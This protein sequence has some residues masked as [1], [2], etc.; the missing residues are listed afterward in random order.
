MVL[1]IYAPFPVVVVVQAAFDAHF[2]R[3]FTTQ[4]TYAF[5]VFGG[6]LLLQILVL[7]WMFAPATEGMVICIGFALGASCCVVQASGHQMISAIDPTKIV[8]CE[9]G[10]QIGS[11][12][13][14]VMISVLDFKPKATPREF[15]EFIAIPVIVSFSAMAVLMV[16]HLSGFFYK[17]YLRLAYDLE[18]DDLQKDVEEAE[19]VRQTSRQAATK[20]L[21]DEPIEFSL[22]AA[23]RQATPEAEPVSPVRR[24]FFTM[25]RSVPG[26]VYKWQIG[27]G[28]TTVLMAFMISLAGFYGDPAY[29]QFLASSKLASDFVGRASSLPL[30]K[31]SYFSASPC[32]RF[33]AAAVVARVVM[34]AVMVAQLGG[35]VVPKPVFLVV[36]CSFNMLDRMTAAFVDVTCGAFVEVKDRRFVS[37]LTFFFGFGGL[38][39]GLGVAALVAVPMAR[40]MDKFGTLLDMGDQPTGP[41][42]SLKSVRLASRAASRL[43]VALQPR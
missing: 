34:V 43:H 3:A 18:E 27:K 14:I 28:F 1:A 32:H 42:F 7:V 36:W 24:S 15:R 22:K 10:G 9:I 17:A 20:K 41:N 21:L 8:F 16:L 40:H 38:I 6:L 35:D 30:V 12:V 11:V 31:S 23:S 19:R 2:D 26:W 33:L 5:R 25:R 4:V 39:L 13:P 29:T 37:R